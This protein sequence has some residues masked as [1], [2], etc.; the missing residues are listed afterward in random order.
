M[1]KVLILGING[2]IGK[3]FQDYIIKRKLSKDYAFIGVDKIGTDKL[4]AINYKKIE[5]LDYA[6]F[7]KL[8]LKETPDYIINLTGIFNSGD[9]KFLEDVNVGISRSIFEIILKKGIKVKN[10]LLIGSAAEY[11][12]NNNL[13]IKENEPL[14]PIN[15]YGL[16]KALQTLYALFFFNNFG[17][18]FNI[19]R[20]FNLVGTDIST[21][22]SVGSFANQIKN[23]ENEII[24]VGNLNTKRDFL[25][26]KDGICA[27]W[28]I[29]INGR[30]GEIYNV[31]SGR[32]YLMKDILDFLIKN[33]KKK[34][35]V[36]V[37]KKLFKRNDILDS[38]GDNSKL[39][40]DTG[41]KEEDNIFSA[42]KGMLEG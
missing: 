25:N 10:I 5:L 30:K 24:H 18:N 31:C 12:R 39:K 27:F 28:K 32:S 3:H 19:A 4:R 23:T 6:N 35:K 14:N 36:S 16:T 11:G 41:W 38:F 1:D 21:S 40:K 13:P 9:F 7:Q 42:L 22:L 29:L 8:I 26:V 17:I 34:L 2:F 15:P 37:E 33:S 20:T